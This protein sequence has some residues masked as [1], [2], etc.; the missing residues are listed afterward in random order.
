MFT[1][2][3]SEDYR[4]RAENFSVVLGNNPQRIEQFSRFFLFRVVLFSFCFSANGILSWFSPSNGGKGV[5][6]YRRGSGI[7]WHV[8]VELVGQ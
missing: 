2:G 7:G 5:A 4:E 8:R 6:I 1:Q 3:S